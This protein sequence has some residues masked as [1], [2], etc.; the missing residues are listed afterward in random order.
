MTAH[1]LYRPHPALGLDAE[2]LCAL[3]SL[4]RRA[5][6]LR[7]F[8]R[9]A[10]MIR[11]QLAAVLVGYILAGTALAGA[12]PLLPRPALHEAVAQLLSD[13]RA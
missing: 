3:R 4:A 10:L 7:P 11:L 6:A 8:L 13:P 2:D 9:P 5:A 1:S 12:L